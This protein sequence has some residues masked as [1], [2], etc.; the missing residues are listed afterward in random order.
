M[1]Q[2]AGVRVE[3]SAQVVE[4][5]L[6]RLD[7][8]RA[9][10]RGARDEVAVPVQVL[11]RAVQRE[12]EPVRERPEPEG[13]REGIVDQRDESA[14]A[15][16]L[17]R[18]VEVGYL[19]QRVGE[20]LEIDR[21]GVP[22]ELSLPRPR[23]LR[24]EEGHLDPQ[25]RQ[26]ARHQ[27]VRAA[28]ESVLRQQVVAGAEHAEQGGGD[29]GHP[30]GGR[31]RG[32]RSFERGELLVQGQMVGRVGQ[33]RVRNVVVTAVAALDEGG[34]LEHGQGDGAPDAR[35]RLACVDEESL[36]LHGCLLVVRMPWPPERARWPSD[37]QPAARSAEGLEMK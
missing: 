6:D 5:V 17:R 18:R 7:A 14:G 4:L 15:R 27:I 1:Q 34:G 29:G 31:Q 10:H 2:E 25:P 37:R 12:V 13:R 19:Q 36:D 3:R 16:E 23:G 28:V 26:I 20:R 8:C 22:P 9:S 32:L 30:A 24:V 11:G 35:P 21:P 33:A